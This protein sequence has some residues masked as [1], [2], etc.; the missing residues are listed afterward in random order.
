MFRKLIF[1]AAATFAVAACDGSR[2]QLE[3]TLAQ[4][5]QIS[6]EK[7]S[8]LK[9]VMAT[10]QFIT[11][12][13]AELAKVRSRTAGRPVQGQP[14]E[15]ENGLTPA[16]QREA[17]RVKVAELTSRLTESESR[18]AASRTRVRDLTA[19]NTALSAQ[20]TAYDS[21]IASFTVLIDNQRTEIASLTEQVNALQAENVSLRQDKASL[22]DANTQLTEQKEQLI[23][24]QNTVYYVIGTE[25]ELSRKG[26]IAKQGGL[27]GIG[28]TAVPAAALNPADFIPIDRTQ[29]M[30]IA[31]P[32]GDKAYKIVSRQD[33]AGLE[34]APDKSNRIKGGLKIVDAAKFWGPARYLILMEQ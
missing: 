26:I 5:E 4:V 10:S 28:K 34:T 25:D 23:T 15:M 24:E 8:L 30:E 13:N 19:N 3:Q 6:A 11:E 31:F 9:D 18:L 16:Q 29:V 22:T 7:D 14:G 17:I 21:T 2:K 12:V 1:V 32:K 20:M 33:V 27:F